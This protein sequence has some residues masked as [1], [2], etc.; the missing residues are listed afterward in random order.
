MDAI[1]QKIKANEKI[2]IGWCVLGVVGCLMLYG[3]LQASHAFNI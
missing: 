2:H 3:V 1:W